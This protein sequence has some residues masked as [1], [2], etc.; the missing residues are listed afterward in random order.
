MFIKDWGG[1]FSTLSARHEKGCKKGAKRV[2]KD[3]KRV[4]KGCKRVQ[5][6]RENGR[7]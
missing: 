3:A 4:Q 6:G 2:Q 7:L 5:K 1:F